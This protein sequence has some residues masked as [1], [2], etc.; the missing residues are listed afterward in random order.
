MQAPALEQLRL[1]GSGV[2]GSL[3]LAPS[4]LLSPA[5]SSGGI[6]N[7][8]PQQHPDAG[9]ALQ[10]HLSRVLSQGLSQGFAQSA[11]QLPPNVAALSTLARLACTGG[12]A[13]LTAAAVA[14]AAATGPEAPA[15]QAFAAQA[16][17]PIAGDERTATNV[18]DGRPAAMQARFATARTY[19]SCHALVA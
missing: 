8:L 5:P 3:S 19:P 9:A 17:H 16:A 14:G 12:L 11:Q 1:Q 18:P 10:G 15:Q 2:I 4:S 6:H 13:G 7:L